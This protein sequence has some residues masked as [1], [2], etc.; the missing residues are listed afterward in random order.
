M[1]SHQTELDAIKNVGSRKLREASLSKYYRSPKYC[2]QCH[3]VIRVRKKQKVSET[4]SKKFC[5]HSCAASYNNSGHTSFGPKRTVER[6][7]NCI[8][9]GKLI[10]GNNRRFC[11]RK[12]FNL[13]AKLKREKN[14]IH[15][16]NQIEDTGIIEGRKLIRRYLIEKY[17]TICSICEKT[18][19]EG[20]PIPL[21][22][23]HID[24]N[25]TNGKLNNL[26]MVCPNCDAL[27]PT[28]TGRNR[29]KGRKSRGVK[30]CS[31]I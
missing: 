15:L 14:W 2:V 19:W 27:L 4:R 21:V 5:N 3:E 22:A 16:K 17:G 20:R 23:D 30:R 25:A 7:D 12:C 1:T 26:R 8:H 28:Y 10:T 24:G 13:F 6:E 11:S 9:C 31:S 29:G 18:M